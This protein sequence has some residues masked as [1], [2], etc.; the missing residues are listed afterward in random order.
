M[1]VPFRIARM[2]AAHG[3]SRHRC[4]CRGCLGASACCC[5]C[6]A[7][8]ACAAASAVATRRRCWCCPVRSNAC[9]QSGVGSR[10]PVERSLYCSRTQVRMKAK[11]TPLWRCAPGPALA[12][13]FAEPPALTQKNRLHKFCLAQLALWQMGTNEQ[14]ITN[15][16]AIGNR[17]ARSTG[18]RAGPEIA[19]QESRQSSTALIN[20]RWR[21]PPLPLQ[22]LSRR[23]WR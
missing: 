3:W 4:S 15:P 22:G 13:R 12:P 9:R 7:S 1:P 18:Q 11:C 19:P 10:G 23:P 16:A 8:V 5:S 17:K 20:S 2:R 21:T 14:I 6:W